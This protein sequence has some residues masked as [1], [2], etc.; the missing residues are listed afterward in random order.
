MI[1][2]SFAVNLKYILMKSP[3]I[4]ILLI[5]FYS[6]SNQNNAAVDDL[7]LTDSLTSDTIFVDTLIEIESDPNRI[8][9]DVEKLL[10]KTN[11]E[12]ELPLL[13]DSTFIE[14][15]AVTG[16]EASYNLTY[17]EARYLGFSFPEGD[18]VSSGQWNIETFI[19]LD[20]LKTN[21]GYDDYQANIDIGQ[22]RYSVGQII[23][24][25]RINSQSTLLLWSLD[26]ATYEACPWGAGT[27][28]FGTVFTNNVGTNTCL[29]AENSGGGDP[30]SWGNTYVQTEISDSTLTTFCLDSWGEYGYDGEDDYIETQERTELVK[31][32]SYGF[33]L[34]TRGGDYNY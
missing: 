3:S 20:S 30:P 32:N 6:C 19:K 10:A 25:L 7:F 21:G 11:L 22:T 33:E 27:Y 8:E 28:I 31:V 24:K 12:F 4:L 26:Y 9:I 13:V 2:V 5:L 17:L 16:Q 23:G 18:L 14:T 1:M 34:I 29:L 15:N